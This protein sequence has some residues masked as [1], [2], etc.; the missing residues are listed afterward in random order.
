[1]RTGSIAIATA[2]GALTVVAEAQP[3]LPPTPTPNFANAVIKTTD[4]GNRIYLLEG[5]GGT[6][7]G[8]VVLAA[9][10]DG[11]ILGGNMFSQMYGKRKGAAAALTTQPGWGVGNTHF[12]RHPTGRDGG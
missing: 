4:L 2:L 3:C 7:G 5:V 11:V 12:P 8:N 10:E 1:M 6:V 9:G